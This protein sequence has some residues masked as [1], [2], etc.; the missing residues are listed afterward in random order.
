MLPLGLPLPFLSRLPPSTSPRAEH[1]SSALCKCGR[2][3]RVPARGPEAL[4]ALMPP[5]VFSSPPG[6]SSCSR[7][8]GPVSAGAPHREL[9]S[10]QS[11]GAAR[12]PGPSPGVWEG[13]SPGLG[14]WP[15]CWRTPWRWT[16]TF[17]ES[18]PEPPAGCRADE[19]LT[20]ERPHLGGGRRGRPQ[21]GLSPRAPRGARRRVSGAQTQSV[22][23]EHR[24]AQGLLPR[25]A[26]R[27]APAS[28]RARCAEPHVRK[29]KQAFV[30]CVCLANDFGS[31]RNPSGD[32]STNW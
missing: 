16:V 2:P 13:R 6:E 8:R 21:P 1:A 32:I 14:P 11:G 10:R 5:R 4:P 23:G 22:R 19:T 25:R 15:L 29:H 9:G 28:C 3:F 12:R 17:T 7:P 18:G 24:A 30:Y 31:G 27:R 26:P 20:T